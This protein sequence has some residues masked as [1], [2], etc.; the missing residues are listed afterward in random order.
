MVGIYQ[1]KKEF[2]VME[3]HF[4][5][6]IAKNYGVNEAIFLNHMAFWLQKN[7]ANN[8]HFYEGRHWTYN[9]QKALIELFPYWSRQ[10]FRTITKSCIDKGLIITGNFNSISYDRTLWYTLTDL[11]LSLFSC[12]NIV[13]TLGENQPMDWP[14]PT[15]ERVRTNPPIP[16]NNPVNNTDN[17]RSCPADAER[18]G[19]DKFWSLYP[20]KENRKGALQI[21]NNRGLEAKAEEIELHLMK[22][23]ESEWAVKDKQYMPMP[24]TF[25]NGER[26]MDDL[27]VSSKQKEMKSVDIQHLFM[28]RVINAKSRERNQSVTNLDGQSL[29]SVYHNLQR[30]LDTKY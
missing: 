8:K 23:L 21:W 9:T 26:W 19:F 22:R 12:F 29:P 30:T 28:E 7:K 11:G 15:I 3:H 6:E 17:K 25:L 13:H 14:K 10:N 16:Y 5:I 2:V 18:P 27:V 4:N 1:P 20:R 24:T